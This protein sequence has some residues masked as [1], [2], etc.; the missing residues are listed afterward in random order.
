[1][2][3]LLDTDVVSEWMKPHPDSGV[4]TWLAEVDEDRVYLSVVSLAELRYG[5]DRLPLKAHRSR[6][7][8]W[9]CEDLPIRFE[10]RILPVDLAVA[11]SWGKM[12]ARGKSVGRTQSIMDGFLAATAEVHRLTMVTRNAADFSLWRFSYR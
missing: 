10:N 8:R 11:E 4:I 12:A 1:M 3:F 5:I 9:L 6:L 7:D 2:S